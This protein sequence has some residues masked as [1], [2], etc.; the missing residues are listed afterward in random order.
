MLITNKP[1]YGL[2]G[3]Y[4]GFTNDDADTFFGISGWS[5]QTYGVE[6]SNGVTGQVK[7]WRDDADC[8]MSC[9]RWDP[10]GSANAGDWSV[11]AT[12]TLTGKPVMTIFEKPPIRRTLSAF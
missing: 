9:G 6:S 7:V 5:G 1:P 12:I 11:G 4:F 2:S 10:F 8:Q 3:Q